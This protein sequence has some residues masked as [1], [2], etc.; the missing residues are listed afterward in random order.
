V[1]VTLEKGLEKIEQ[2]VETGVATLDSE[3]KI[4]Q[5]AIYFFDDDLLRA[6]KLRSDYSFPWLHKFLRLQKTTLSIWPPIEHKPKQVQGE[7]FMCLLD[8]QESFRLVSSVFKQNLYSGV[9]DDLPPTEI[10]EDI[11]LFAVNEAKY[12][13]LKQ[14]ET[15]IL[16]A[17]LNGG[18]CIYIPA[19]YWY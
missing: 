5:P 7:T 14:V 3:G 12:P 1:P 17:T 13:L 4:V 9:Y 11:D 10:P 19:Y 6:P 15:H 8:G 18:D 16:K 2:N